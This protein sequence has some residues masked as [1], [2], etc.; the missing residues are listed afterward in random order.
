MITGGLAG[1][2]E[3][4]RSN[5]IQSARNPLIQTVRRLA[6]PR[7][8]ESRFLLEGRKLVRAALASGFE[9]ER[10]LVSR[11]VPEEEKVE[12][13]ASIELVEVS[14]RVFGQ[15]SSLDSPEGLL[16]LARRPERSLSQLRPEGFIV[17]SAGIQDPGNLGAVARVAEAAGCS[18]LVMLRGSCDPFGPKALR[19]SMGSLL[20]IPVYE[21]EDEAA[22]R[23]RGFE[24]A[25]L[26]PRDGV[27]FRQVSY[28]P[29]LALLLGRESTGLGESVLRHARVRITIPMKGEVDSM[30]V[31]TAAALVL[32][33]AIRPRD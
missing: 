1:V 29:P 24:I 12:L 27:D 2:Q 5:R 23:A 28:R 7:R 31:A 15:L 25:A 22:V 30:N 14:D 8:R 33:E 17:V 16:A 26:V 6:H 10:V 3:R 21:A 9:V 11:R 19:G 20:R 13:G 32:Y 18:A 4:N